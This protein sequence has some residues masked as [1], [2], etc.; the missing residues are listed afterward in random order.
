MYR[1]VFTGAQGTGKTTVLKEMEALGCNVITEV[2]RNLR[3]QG[4]KINEDGDKKGQ[5]K[6]FNTYKELLAEANP[7]GYISDR[8]LVDVLAYTIYL[9]NHGKIKDEKFVEK[10]KKQ[11]V[12]FIRENPDIIYCYY[13]IEFELVAD[14]CRSEDEEFR[15]EIDKI[16]KGILEGLGLNYVLIRGEVD[17]RVNKVKRLV[18]WLIEGCMLFTEHMTNTTE[19]ADEPEE[20]SDEFVQQA[21]DYCSDKVENEN[22]SE[23]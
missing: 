7:L 10:Q 13:P 2:V 23:L 8:C 16:I 9:Y 22:V 20:N 11:L 18:N 15:S 6:I 3:E 4:V 14:G 12:N 19:E 21:L 17:E 1:I 5:T